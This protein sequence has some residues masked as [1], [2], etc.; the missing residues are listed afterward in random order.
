MVVCL[1]LVAGLLSNGAN[2]L[3]IAASAAHQE[4]APPVKGKFQV[5]KGLV[6][7]PAKTKKARKIYPQNTPLR[8][9]AGPKLKVQAVPIGREAAEP[10][11]ALLEDGSAYF[12]AGTFDGPGGAL[13]R[14]EIYRSTDGG[15][16][17]ESVQPEIAPGQHESPQTLDPYVYADPVGGRVFSVDLY[18]VTGSYLLWTDDGGETW[19]RNPLASAGWSVD[20]QTFMSGPPPEGIETNGY[21]SVLYYCTNWVAD[22][23]CS[24]SMDGGVVWQPTGEPAFYGEDEEAG[25][26]CG[27]LHGHAEVDS[28]G[29]L[30]LPKGHCNSPWVAMSEDMGQSWTRTMVPK[31]PQTAGPH[32]EIATDSED[33]VYLVWWSDNRQLPYLAISRDHGATWS[34]P[35]M[36]APPGVKHTNFPVVAAGDR[37]RIAI[38]F[39][40]TT[41]KKSDGIRPWNDYLVMSKNALAKNPT[42]VSTTVNPLSDPVHRGNCNGRCGGMFDFLDLFV[43][44]HDG[45]IWGAIADNCVDLCATGKAPVLKQTGDGVAVRQLS[46]FSMWDKDHEK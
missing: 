34:K 35:R 37:G 6:H 33:N 24:R 36:I 9:Y 20:H 27:G 4:T 21:P 32:I 38:L 3:P 13:A 39:P 5:Y 23:A 11:I 14:T 17:W 40:G 22:A 43:S 19:S 41:Q 10:T 46:G 45:S 31:A 28:H 7:K 16:K 26:F 8:G 42:F 1:G 12:A 30:F 2:S 18:T 44:P 15:V 29:R 25:G